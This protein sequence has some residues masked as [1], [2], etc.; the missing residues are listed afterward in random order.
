MFIGGISP[1]TT[2][3]KGPYINDHKFLS[4]VLVPPPPNFVLIASIRGLRNLKKNFPL[5][6]RGGTIIILS[7]QQQQ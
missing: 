3:S 1:I 4:V 6:L 5:L 7:S 2:E